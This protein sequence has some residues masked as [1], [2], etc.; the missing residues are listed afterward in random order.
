MGINN[1]RTNLNYIIKYRIA[2]K[3]YLIKKTKTIVVSKFLYYS[4]NGQI[5]N[6]KIKIIPVTVKT[7]I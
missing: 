6:V 3:Y 2:Y 4:I 5:N 1:L 7:I